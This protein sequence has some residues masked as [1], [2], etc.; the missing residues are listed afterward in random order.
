M[1]ESVTLKGPKDKNNSST[2]LFH[3]GHRFDQG[4][5]VAVEDAEVLKD[6]KGEEFGKLYDFKFGKATKGLRSA[7]EQPDIA[8]G[9]VPAA[10]AG[11]SDPTPAGG[12]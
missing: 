8:P 1:A 2:V 9:V 5:E 10:D 3:R 11:D 12:R 4:V 6:L 7:K